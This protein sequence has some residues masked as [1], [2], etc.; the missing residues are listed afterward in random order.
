MTVTERAYL[1]ICP[2][3]FTATLLAFSCADRAGNTR[4]DMGSAEDNGTDSAE[5][6]PADSSAEILQLLDAGCA[7]AV[8]CEDSTSMWPSF[9]PVICHPSA[10]EEALDSLAEVMANRAAELDLAAISRCIE[11]LE[12]NNCEG[13]PMFERPCEDIFVGKLEDGAPCTALFQCRDGLECEAGVDETCSYCRPVAMPGEPCSVTEDCAYDAYCAT[14]GV[15]IAQGLSGDRCASHEQCRF[16]LLCIEG[17]CIDGVP[18]GG[19]CDPE[20]DLCGLG[21]YCSGIIGQPVCVPGAQSGGT[22]SAAIPCGATGE[23]CVDNVCLPVAGPNDPCTSADQCVTGLVCAE[24][25]C[26]PFPVVGE[27]CD[28]LLSC[29]EGA[30]I[31]GQCVLLLEGQECQ[32][33][34]SCESGRC[35][36]E[37]DTCA[38]P[39][40]VGDSCGWEVCGDGLFCSMRET[41]EGIEHVCEVA[42]CE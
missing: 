10:Q 15:C 2:L 9:R 39:L 13:E 40:G 3:V 19:P 21:L 36:S 6:I 8:R 37:T 33:D 23:R 29:W 1:P 27:P 41:D 30:C 26:A 4:T 34:M 25:R 35:S 24:G 7:Y 38:P 14:S 16:G 18:T 22:C 31:D 20:Q 42:S 11:L 5:E 28:E 12:T 32:Y 17:F